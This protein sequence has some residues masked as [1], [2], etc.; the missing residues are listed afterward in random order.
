MYLLRGR[1]VTVRDLIDYG[2][3]SDGDVLTFDR[4]RIGQTHTA[5]VEAR[6]SLLMDGRSY[7]TPSAAACAAAGL[8]QMD[9]WSAWVTDRGSSLHALRTLLLDRVAAEAAADG[10]AESLEQEAGE[11][12]LDAPAPQ[13][14]TSSLL[15]RHEFLKGARQAA[16]DE[17]PLAISV[18]ELLARWGGRARGHD[19]SGRIEA[20]LYNRG[21][22]TDPNFRQVALDDDV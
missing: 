5:S 21:L 3:L 19:I 13:E 17:R 22:R 16:E 1:R 20:D 10:A 11:G 15:P 6:G 14:P 4:P 9:G 2:L 18:R 12:G 8:T 7:K